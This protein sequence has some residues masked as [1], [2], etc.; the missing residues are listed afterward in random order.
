MQGR[1]IPIRNFLIHSNAGVFDL[2]DFNRLHIRIGYKPWI[3]R[4]LN[5]TLMVC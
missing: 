4:G 1:K 2:L 3:A 5:S